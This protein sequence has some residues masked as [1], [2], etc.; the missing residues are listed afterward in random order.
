MGL[1]KS[2]LQGYTSF[3]KLKI[4][5]KMVEAVLEML[6]R[7]GSVAVRPMRCREGRFGIGGYLCV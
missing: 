6:K 1:L 7:G 5:I 2:G 3:I 4:K